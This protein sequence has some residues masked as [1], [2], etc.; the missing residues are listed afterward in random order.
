[1]DTFGRPSQLLKRR[2]APDDTEREQAIVRLGVATVILAYLVVY[3]LWN[4]GGFTP[5]M[6][7]ILILVG[8]LGVSLAFLT[9]IVLR[10]G[11]S[12]TRRVLANIGDIGATSL[13]ML[14]FGEHMGPLYIVYLWVTIGNGL[15]FGQPYL[16]T[17]IGL[18]IVGFAVVLLGNPYWQA[19]QILGWG[20]MVGLIVLPAYFS[21]LL[22]RVTRAH[23][24]A[25]A[26][27]R[28]KSQFLANMSHEIR[29]P[30]N[31]V[32]G[33]ADLLADTPLTPMQRRFTDTLQRSA[34]GL[35]ELL[36]HVLD[37][38]RIEAGKV[39]PEPVDFDL[40]AL[41][42][43]TADMLRH[44]VER[45]G[46]ELDI[47]I[48]PRMPFLVRGDEMRVRQ[49]LVNLGSN[50]VKFTESGR[51]DIRVARVD[52]G[53][54]AAAKVRLEV[55]DTGIGMSEEARARIFELFTQADGS[56]TREYGGTGLG[57]TIAKQLA[58]LL[59]G[60]IALESEPGS[61]TIF[62]VTLPF[63]IADDTTQAEQLTPGG[64]VFV[65]TR[66]RLLARALSDWF[67]TWGLECHALDD[68]DECLRRLGTGTRDARAVFVDEAQLSD[69]DH[70][71]AEARAHSEGTGLVLLRRTPTTENGDDLSGRF[72]AELDLPTE[73]PLV[74]NALYAVQSELPTDDRVID[75]ARHRRAPDH[76]QARARI[77]VADDN[78]TNQE[79]IRLILES[80]GHEARIVSDGEEAL[81]ALEEATYDLALI[82]MHMP[83]RSGIDVIKTWRFMNT[84][85]PVTPMVLLTADTSHEARQEAESAGAVACLTK[86]VGAGDLTQLLRRLLD[87]EAHRTPPPDA[88]PDAARESRSTPAA[89]DSGNATEL[90]SERTL[91]QLAGM[92]RDPAFLSDLIENFLRDA[93][94]LIEHLETAEAAGD[95]EGIHYHAHA[96]HG[97]AG[98]LGVQAIAEAAAALRHADQ[99][100]LRTGT[101]GYELGTLRE[102]LG[103]TRPALLV[104]ASGQLRR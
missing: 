85:G 34:R 77:L 103:R 98:N 46:L 21:S 73:K 94:K 27:N 90:V 58:E 14:L 75:L 23:A 67:H 63:G 10:P 89:A 76:R 11:H 96:L 28:A 102:L 12:V 29:T 64:R 81:D 54:T 5:L 99:T 6:G 35:T 70:F 55:A 66:D 56:I 57:T 79:V 7:P 91:Q 15:R 62:R 52:D 74:F 95:L 40:Y 88:T 59:G 47:H 17:S 26:A 45:K 36:S 48:D 53:S 84:S 78:A 80:A 32:I 104:H 22:A 33:M 69:A 13:V 19:N 42:K 92:A 87:G 49:I 51:I 50:A 43:D 31:G 4:Y 68:M 93:E 60:E 24:E 2:H 3:A 30:M 44:E 101:V 20:L 97:S 72:P 8:F 71:L 61:G 82:D 18:S 41:V 37:L 83:H 16:Y 9:D 38:S 1:M 65:L 86:P 100:D 25:E 39:Q